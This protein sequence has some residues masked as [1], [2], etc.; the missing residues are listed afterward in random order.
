[1]HQHKVIFFIIS[2]LLTSCSGDP[3]VTHFPGIY[4]IDIQQ[5]NIV[6]Q[7]TVNQLT[8]GMP[9]RQVHFIMG[10]PLITDTFHRNRWDYFFT[11]QKGNEKMTKSHIAI[12]FEDGKLARV[13]GDYRPLPVNKV[14]S[15]ENIISVPPK[16]KRKGLVGRSLETIGIDVE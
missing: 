7:E 1:M 3:V 13:E 16:K 9:I 15:T 5:G 12:F 6:T 8:P 14:A 4:R 10:T 11:N 2:V